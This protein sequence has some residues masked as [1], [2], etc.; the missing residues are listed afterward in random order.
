[1]FF[2]QGVKYLLP[3]KDLNTRKRARLTEKHVKNEHILQWNSNIFYVYLIFRGKIHSKPLKA[4][5]CMHFLFAL[6]ADFFA[7]LLALS[8][9]FISTKMT[10]L[11]IIL[12]HLSAYYLDLFE[13]EQL[14]SINQF[15]YSQAMTGFPAS[16]AFVYTSTYLRVRR[17]TTIQL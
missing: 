16:F 2:S 3:L 1:M 12:W 11:V 14:K 15:K 6:F 13:I 4:H 17:Y 10:A 7:L 9:L 5:F 8:A